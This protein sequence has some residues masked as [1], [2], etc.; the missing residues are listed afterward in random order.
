MSVITP[1]IELYLGNTRWV[2]LRLRR[3]GVRTPMD[4]SSAQR[5]AVEFALSGEPPLPPIY[6]SRMAAGANWIAGKVPVLVTP[7]SLTARVGSYDVAV[8]LFESPLERTVAIGRVEVLPRPLRGLLSTSNGN[9]YVSANVFSMVNGG[10]VT[11]PTGAPIAGTAQ[12]AVLAQAAGALLPA[13]GVAIADTSPRSTCLYIVSGQIRL[14]DW[15]IV[16]GSPSLPIGAP[17]IWL[18]S[19]AGTTTDD[20]PLAPT[21]G[22]R[23]TIGSVANDPQLLNVGVALGVLL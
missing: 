16:F 3:Y 11:I 2:N 20:L 13:I 18:G 19:T 7:A 1:G 23:Q 4:V 15:T 14:S 6:A 9:A 10:S 17:E 22:L 5:I 12:G 8:T 21:F